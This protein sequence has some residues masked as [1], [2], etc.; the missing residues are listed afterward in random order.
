MQNFGG[1]IPCEISTRK[2][3][4]A[5]ELKEVGCEN[6]RWMNLARDP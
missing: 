1:E 3:K 6:L 5:V 4:K 2:T